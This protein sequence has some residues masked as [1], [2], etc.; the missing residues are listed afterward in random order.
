MLTSKSLP[1]ICSFPSRRPKF[2]ETLTFIPKPDVEVGKCWIPWK[3]VGESLVT[4]PV[5]GKVHRKSNNYI[6]DNYH[7]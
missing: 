2:P 5:S 3:H 6:L 7:E 4:F 1:L